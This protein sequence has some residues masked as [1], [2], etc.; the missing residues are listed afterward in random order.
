[1]ILTKIAKMYKKTLKLSSFFAANFV[2]GVHT[3]AA[4][5]LFDA[6]IGEAA[7]LLPTW[8]SSH[9]DEYVHT[10]GFDGF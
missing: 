8:A 1:M 2:V 9:E 3:L 5:A 4:T 7:E 10:F 6:G